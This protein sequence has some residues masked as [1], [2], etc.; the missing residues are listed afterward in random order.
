M[1]VLYSAFQ[2]TSKLNQATMCQDMYVMIK[3]EGDTSVQPQLVIAVPRDCLFD[4]G[5]HR[6]LLARLRYRVVLVWL[7]GVWRIALLSL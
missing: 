3:S 6:I 5:E 2:R 1:R 7:A 4:N